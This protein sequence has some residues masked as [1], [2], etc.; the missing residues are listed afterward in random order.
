MEAV[1]IDDQRDFKDYTAY[2]LIALPPQVRNPIIMKQL[3]SQCGPARLKT[4]KPMLSAKGMLL[5]TIDQFAILNTSEKILIH[6]LNTGC[7]ENIACPESYVLFWVDENYLVF[8]KRANHHDSFI[9]QDKK[10]GEI[11]LQKKLEKHR[12]VAAAQ[13]G[14][15]IVYSP[16]K[17]NL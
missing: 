2:E 9:I 5:P 15:L 13:Y 8:V 16:Q 14:I 7:D 4:Q 1:K 10:S 17:A 3:I 6:N 11:L 12:Y